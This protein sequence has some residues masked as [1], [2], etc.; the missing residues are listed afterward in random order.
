MRKE[1][2]MNSYWGKNGTRTRMIENILKPDGNRISAQVDYEYDD[3]YRLVY[4]YR[5]T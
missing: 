5:Q 2:W 4:C 3:L 1:G